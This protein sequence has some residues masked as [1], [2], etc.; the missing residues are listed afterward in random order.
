M[1]G[2]LIVC[3][4][5]FKCN[6]QLAQQILVIDKTVHQLN[7]HSI[8]RKTHWVMQSILFMVLKT[9]NAFYGQIMTF[10]TSVNFHVYIEIRIDYW[11]PSPCNS[12][13]HICITSIQINAKSEKKSLQQQQI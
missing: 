12:M 5:F 9:K 2:F 3:K 6:R 11:H 8:A 10:P 7:T 1:I 13:Q 4:Q